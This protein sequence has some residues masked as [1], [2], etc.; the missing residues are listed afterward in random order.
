M[1]MRL[2]ET[3]APAWAA[4]LAATVVV[5]AVGQTPP[6]GSAVIP[7]DALLTTPVGGLER[8]AARSE[9]IGV[10]GMP[11][12]KALRVTINRDAPDTNATQLTILNSAR[13]ERGDVM[14]A[15]FYIR[16]RSA[17]GRDPAQA[18]FLF[19][20]ATSPWTKSASQGASAPTES[21]KWRA[22]H[23]PFRAAESYA[24][25]EAMASMRFAFGPQTVDIGGLEVRSFGKS[26]SLEEVVAMASAR[27][28]IGSVTVTLK[29]EQKAQKMV[30]LG[31]NF[32]QPRY[33]ATEPMDAVGRWN[34]DH[35]KVAHARV[36]IPLNWWTP[37]PNVYKDEA[38]AHASF[39]LMQELSRRRIPIVGSVWEGPEWM[40]GGRRE[41]MG[42]TLPLDKYDLC[43]EAIA[44]Y[45]VT[46][47]DKYGVTVEHFS[48]NEADIGVNFRFTP[49]QIAEF[50]RRAGPR[51]RALGLKT[52]FLVGDTANGMAT[53]NYCRPLLTE[54]TL[55]P[56]LGPIAF[57]CWDALSAPDKQY[58]AIA[59][60]GREFG[61]PVW[62]LE[63][64]HDAQLWQ[65]PNPWQSWENALRTALAYERTI[66]LTGATIMDYWTYQD[67]YPL[68]SRD[69]KTP[70]PVFHVMAQMERVFTQ[71]S[72]VIAV[73]TDNEDVRALA[74][75]GPKTGRLAALIVNP[76]GPGKAKVK[77]FAQAKP[78]RIEI[79]SSDAQRRSS[80][81]APG[82]DRRVTVELP[83]RSVVTMVQSE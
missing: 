34:L 41:Q 16:G 83:A 30:G 20:R 82:A 22:V 56:Y 33:G 23:V 25:G 17:S 65:Q 61:K 71:G 9:V 40:L 59:A 15:S 2:H 77:G 57:H 5:M 48:F 18:M 46:A 29:P 11:F 43:I 7:D 49:A 52:K 63:A 54:A 1:A 36:G 10:S 44:R 13:V 53:V 78:V 68:V 70:F 58:A 73:T 45:L 72:T 51:F 60:L 4:L 27:S 32:C 28:P 64:G 14:L 21:G 75:L 8:T 6:D 69:G 31:G 80:T 37:E 81:V 76:S 66:R 26:Q 50:I 79:S 19:E 55:A 12:S 38:Q 47:R 74:T 67:N 24:P 3:G 62:C 35:L 42:R 39:L